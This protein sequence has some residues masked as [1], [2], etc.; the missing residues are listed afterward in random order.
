MGK[1]V[2]ESP[3]IEVVDMEAEQCFA[4]SGDG[5]GTGGDWPGFVGEGDGTGTGRDWPDFQ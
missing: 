4:G 5:T 1:K 2:Y 3:S